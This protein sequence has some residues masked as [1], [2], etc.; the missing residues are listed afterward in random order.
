MEYRLLA[1]Y[2]FVAICVP[3]ISGAGIE[4][5]SSE[6]VT[7]GPIVT[8]V[9]RIE[10]GGILFHAYHLSDNTITLLGYASA[11]G[12]LGK[13]ATWTVPAGW[14]WQ[15]IDYYYINGINAVSAPFPTVSWVAANSSRAFRFQ[16]GPA[17]QCYQTATSIPLYQLP[18]H[19]STTPAQAIIPLSPATPNLLVVSTSEHISLVEVSQTQLTLQSGFHFGSE[20]FLQTFKAPKLTG[21]F[22]DKVTSFGV[23]YHQLILAFAA[24]DVRDVGIVLNLKYSAA[25]AWS[26][27]TVTYLPSS[28][29]GIL[30]YRNAITNGLIFAWLIQTPTPDTTGANAFILSSGG[31][32]DYGLIFPTNYTWSSSIASLDGQTHVGLFTCGN[33]SAGFDAW[34][35]TFS[36]GTQSPEVTVGAPS[37][38]GRVEGFGNP[39]NGWR[40]RHAENFEV[41]TLTRDTLTQC[42]HALI[43]GL[44]GAKNLDDPLMSYL[45][46][47]V[48]PRSSRSVN[49]LSTATMNDQDS[50]MS[51]HANC[52][53]SNCN[54]E[55]AGDCPITN[56]WGMHHSGTFH[57]CKR[58]PV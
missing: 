2:L 44:G 17:L 51:A 27:N 12:S 49:S 9:S 46:H 4:I 31:P 14:G 24:D 28:P 41:L 57:C 34:S 11:F 8:A 35:P 13:L 50:Q 25:G 42:W 5:F 26:I 6:N 30:A 32:T 23:P 29:Q 33:S 16:C 15:E 7:C 55:S 22:F 37:R 19:K 21:L 53:P 58:P 48:T 18:S 3:T 56:C 47:D 39:S 10:G 38:L 36:F 40:I 20:P 52:R 45:P 1:L 54:F 43:L